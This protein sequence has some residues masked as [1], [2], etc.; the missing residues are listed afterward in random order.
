[1]SL[2]AEVI[3]YHQYCPT[4]VKRVIATGT[5][6]FIGELDESTVLKYP[7]SPTGDVSRLEIERKLLQIVSPHPRIILLKSFSD[8]A[9][10]LERAANG[11]LAYYL[12]ESG[13]PTPS[14]QQR[15]S[16]CREAAGA[17]AYVHSKR[18]LHCDIQPTNF[19]LDIGLHLKLSDFQGKLLSEQGEVLLDGGSGEPC[20]FYLPRDDPF[21]SDIKTDLFALGC[22]LYFIMM[23]HA[24]FPDII[25]GAEGWHDEVVDRFT[26]QQFPQDIH[27]C[28]SVTLKCWL[29]Q[30]D[31]AEDIIQ[32]INSIERNIATNDDV[33]MSGDNTS[34]WQR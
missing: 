20:R 26:N 14:I 15:L 28:S 25:D 29:K 23:G 1:M 5:S 16:W 6:A 9:L 8:S 12:L 4:G 27:A 34:N 33:H 18:V 31:S 11:C 7:L 3:V 22:T 17:V 24:V 21:D 10:Y 19:L 30:Y 32:E 2:D 13:N